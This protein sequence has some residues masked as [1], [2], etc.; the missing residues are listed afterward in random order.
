MLRS[1]LIKDLDDLHVV[2]V[3]AMMV[4]V[5]A[6]TVALRGSVVLMEVMVVVA[7]IVLI[8]PISVNRNTTLRMEH[9]GLDNLFFLAGHEGVFFSRIFWSIGSWSQ[10]HKCVH[11]LKSNSHGRLFFPY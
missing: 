9:V 5:E 7:D 2:G 1:K 10:F 3:K 4:M 11:I 8:P 6:F